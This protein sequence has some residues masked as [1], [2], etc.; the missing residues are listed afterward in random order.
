MAPIALAPDMG[1]D[2]GL[3]S[4]LAVSDGLKLLVEAVLVCAVVFARAMMHC[5]LDDSDLC[6]GSRCDARIGIVSSISTLSATRLVCRQQN[7]VSC[8]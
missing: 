5:W 3:R 2:L 1:A 4:T 7:G 6:R 8:P